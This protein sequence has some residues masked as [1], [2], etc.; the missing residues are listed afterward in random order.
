MQTSISD[1]INLIYTYMKFVVEQF[2]ELTGI[3]RNIQ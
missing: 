1:K 2:Q 3:V